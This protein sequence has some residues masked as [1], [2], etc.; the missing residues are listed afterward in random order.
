MICSQA[1]LSFN[2]WCDGKKKYNFACQIQV[3]VIIFVTTANS[4]I[5]YFVVSFLYSKIQS[6]IQMT[7]VMSMKKKIIAVCHIVSIRHGSMD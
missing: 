3:Q 1:H 6:F 7:S 4:V 5:I 2:A